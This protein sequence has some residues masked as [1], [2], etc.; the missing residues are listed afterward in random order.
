[1]IWRTST[2]VITYL[3]LKTKLFTTVCLKMAPR[4]SFGCHNVGDFFLT[5]G[6]QILCHFFWLYVALLKMTQRRLTLGRFEKMTLCQPDVLSF[7]IWH[8]VGIKNDF[9][10]ARRC[11]IFSV[12]NLTDVVSFF[13]TLCRSLKNE[14]L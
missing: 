5:A 8:Y 13:L 11:V 12:Q 1:L 6:L 4:L 9:M 7:F 3:A 14:F 10:S 2:L